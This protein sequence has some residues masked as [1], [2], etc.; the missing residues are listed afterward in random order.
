MRV[1]EGLGKWLSNS[2]IEQM[3]VGEWM[4]SSSELLN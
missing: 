1:S 2:A 4:A 3:S